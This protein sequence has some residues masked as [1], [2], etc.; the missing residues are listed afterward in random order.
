MGFEPLRTVV[1]QFEVALPLTHGTDLP[2]C[3]L[4]M[5]FNIA[6]LS[7]SQIEVVLVDTNTCS[8]HAVLAGTNL[9]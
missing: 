2:I 3:I 4:L 5:K 6:Y 1:N 7:I 9:L 8:V